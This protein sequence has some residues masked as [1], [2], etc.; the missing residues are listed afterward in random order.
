MG[1]YITTIGTAGAVN[2]TVTSNYNAIVNDRIFASTA[3]GAFT[4]TLPAT[5]IEGDTV[6]IIDIGGNAGT[7]NITV[8]RNSLKI[9]NL[10]EDL[11]INVSY[12]SITLVYNVTYG[13]VIC[14]S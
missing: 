1:R 6:Q 2:R 10:T 5:P 8:A 13:W 7:N 11:T 4:I 9:Q 12:A 14:G 3:G